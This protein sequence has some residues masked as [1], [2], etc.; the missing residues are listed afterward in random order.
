MN[1][2]QRSF[3][4]GDSWLYIKVYTGYKTADRLLRN[5]IPAVVDRLLDTQAISKWFFIRYSDPELHLRLR[6]LLTDNAKVGI[7]ILLLNQA[8]NR[9]VENDMVWKVQLDTYKREVE[10]YGADTIEFS[11]SLFFC[12]SVCFTQILNA[13]HGE[14]IEVESYRWRLALASIDYL[15]NDF[16]YNLKQKVEF[17]SKVK[18][19]HARE[20]GLINSRSQLSNKFRTHR[21]EIESLLDAQDEKHRAFHLIMETRSKKQ[22]SVC[23]KIIQ[24]IPQS[25]KLNALLSN[26]THMMMNRWFR[27]KQRM[28][29]AVVYDFLLKYYKSKTAKEKLL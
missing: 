11:E 13:L 18:D 16:S 3:F 7:P 1:G 29:E 15:L 9:F 24:L 10:R 25:E 8:L 20:Y 23:E 28:H 27:T 19:N 2:L 5:E 12:D 22:K 14:E 17:V 4:P 26:Y 6:F 21:K